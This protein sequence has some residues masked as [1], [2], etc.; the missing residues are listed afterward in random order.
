MCHFILCLRSTAGNDVSSM[1]KDVFGKG[2]ANNPQAA[3]LIPV[4]MERNFRGDWVCDGLTTKDFEARTERVPNLL[5]PVFNLQTEVRDAGAAAVASFP[6]PQVCVRTPC[7][8]L[9]PC[10]LILHRSNPGPS[11][12]AGGLS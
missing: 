7:T 12:L 8:S 2:F 6:T 5:L 11:V 3:P 1:F 4:F 10:V 9:T